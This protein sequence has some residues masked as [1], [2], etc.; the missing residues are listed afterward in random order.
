MRTRLHD[1][2]GQGLIELVVAMVV[3]TVAVL[4]LMAAYDEGFVSLHKSA[5]T[6]AAATLAE[7]QLELYSSLP[8]T[9]VGLDSTKLATA[10]A[11][12]STYLSDYNSLSPTG[13]DV[14]ISSCGTTANCL[15][16]QSPNPTGSDGRSYKVET[17]IQTVTQNAPSGTTQERMVTVIVRDPQQSGTP[18]VYEASAA[19]DPGPT[20]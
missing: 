4:A 13:P 17:F 3:I 5:R 12:D 19:F 15:P 7:T 1:E 6:N 8:Y 16:V 14:T 20:S 9:A 2:Q 10:K 18:I 11:S